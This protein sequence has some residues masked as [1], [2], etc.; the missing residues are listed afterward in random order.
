MLATGS[1][2]LRSTHLVLRHAS[3]MAERKG[4]VFTR[5]ASIDPV[6]RVFGVCFSLE[7]Y[8]CNNVAT[9]RVRAAV[10]SMIADIH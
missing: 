1:Q 8:S 10:Y 7:L 3:S 4:A 5:G 6:T 2:I 9:S